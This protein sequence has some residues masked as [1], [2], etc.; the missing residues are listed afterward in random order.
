MCANDLVPFFCELLALPDCHHLR[1]GCATAVHDVL[2]VIG[3]NL[4]QVSFFL[5]GNTL[6][7]TVQLIFGDCCALGAT[8]SYLPNIAHHARH[9]RL[10]LRL[11]ISSVGHPRQRRYSYCRQQRQ[12]LVQRRGA[13]AKISFCVLRRAETHYCK[14]D[15]GQHLFAN[16]K[17]ECI[18][19]SHRTECSCRLRWGATL[20]GAEKNQNQRP[21]LHGRQRV[22]LQMLQRQGIRISWELLSNLCSPCSRS[23]SCTPVCNHNTRTPAGD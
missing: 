3:L 23:A 6:Q 5:A 8:R 4:F 22:K 21:R 7:I 12:V 17:I 1:L 18:L 16:T 19:L 14:F 10:Q 20:T 2:D 13:P 15:V 11:D 9:E